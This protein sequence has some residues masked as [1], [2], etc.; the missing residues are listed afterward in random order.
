MDEAELRRI[1]AAFLA[2]AGAGDVGT[3][4]ELADRDRAIEA[5]RRGE[6]RLWFEADLYDQLQL[7]Q[8]LSRLRGL[9]VPAERVTL[10][11]I[12]EHVGFARFGG[13]AELSSEQ[14]RRL[15]DQVAVTL[16]AEALDLAARA[17]AALRAPDPR[18]L[19]AIAG[20][21]SSGLR[22]LAEAF[23]RLGREYPS[24]RDGLSLT[25]RRILAALADGPRSAAQTFVRAAAR[26][27]RPFLGDTWCFDRMRRLAEAPSPLLRGPADGSSVELTRPAG[28]CS[29]ATTTTSRATASTGGS[30]GCTSPAGP[31]LGVGTRASRRSS[32]CPGWDSNPHATKARHFE[33]RV[34]DQFHHP[35]GWP[36]SRPPRAG[37]A[38]GAP[39]PTR[40]RPS[41]RCRPAR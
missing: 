38:A 36:K 10:I 34:Y 29:T 41:S 14:L 18:G 32:R 27:T 9:E 31:S 30:A 21:P 8:I 5:N 11:C 26:E 40:A 19:A 1:R 12:G 13:L 37:R 20:T 6:Y 4:A 2:S 22:F 28:G 25:E 33:C 24:T 15:P 16:T 39:A 17:W 35:G 7:A 3:A 23:D